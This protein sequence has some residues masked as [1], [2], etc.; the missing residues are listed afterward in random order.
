M[1][2]LQRYWAQMV[3]GGIF[4]LILFGL[5]LIWNWGHSAPSTP[6]GTAPAIA[7]PA[8]P[9][10]RFVA[11]TEALRKAEE[12]TNKAT[13][14]ARTGREKLMEEIGLLK[15]KLDSA[16]AAAKKNGEELE[17]ALLATAEMAVFVDKDGF[18]KSEAGRKLAEALERARKNK[19]ARISLRDEIH[20]LEAK[21]L[22]RKTQWEA[23]ARAAN[24]RNTATLRKRAIELRDE[25]KGLEDELAV[26]SSALAAL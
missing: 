2:F 4:L 14:E 26:L 17:R 19:D 7:A 5:R 13:E 25:V 6:A 10:A 22:E 8:A 12:A 18:K 24:W 21:L 20:R 16:T 11:A 1:A 3:V 23:V 9:D 15:D